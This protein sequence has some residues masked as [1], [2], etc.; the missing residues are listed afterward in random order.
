[1]EPQLEATGIARVRQLNGLPF[2]HD[3]MI[4]ALLQEL[5]AYSTLATKAAN[6]LLAHLQ[7]YRS[8]HASLSP[9]SDII[10]NACKEECDWLLTWWRNHALKL[11]TWA[12]LVKTLLAIAP[13]SAAVERAFSILQ[14]LYPLYRLQALK[15]HQELALMLSINREAF[16]FP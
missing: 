7:S 14:N 3:A 4:E 15:G 13:S 5:P 12:A 1:M 10:R 16:V 9:S 2:V 11:P 8:R 6:D